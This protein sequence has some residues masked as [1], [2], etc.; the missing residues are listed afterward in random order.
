[1]CVGGNLF[2]VQLQYSPEE[3]FKGL[4]YCSVAIKKCNSGTSLGVQWLRL[5][6]STAGGMGSIPGP[7]AKIL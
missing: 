3:K 6:A 1:M 4:S 2:P 5:C 7:G